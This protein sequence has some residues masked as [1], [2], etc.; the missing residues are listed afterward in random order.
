[1]T[2]RRAQGSPI[3]LSKSVSPMILKALL[4]EGADGRSSMRGKNARFAQKVESHT[5][6]LRDNGTSTSAPRRI[7]SESRRRQGQAITLWD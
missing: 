3:Q 1:M 2:R 4:I 6:S 5:L 7:K